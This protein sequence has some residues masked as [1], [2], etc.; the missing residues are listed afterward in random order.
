MALTLRL[1]A[2]DESA[3]HELAASLGLLPIDLVRA[4]VRGLLTAAKAGGGKIT[5]PLHVRT[6][7]EE[8]HWARVAQAMDDAAQEF[9][10]KESEALKALAVRMLFYARAANL[11]KQEVESALITLHPAL[12]GTNEEMIAQIEEGLWEQ[13]DIARQ[14]RAGKRGAK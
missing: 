4:S 5:L 12:T 1:P 2:E 8:S 6:S 9:G 14:E 10:K 7:Y 13:R 3:L 11:P